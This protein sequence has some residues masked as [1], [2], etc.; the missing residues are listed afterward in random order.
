MNLFP[1]YL[2]K[3]MYVTGQNSGKTESLNGQI[4]Q[5]FSVDQ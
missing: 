3:T 2:M 5:T 4:D 1:S